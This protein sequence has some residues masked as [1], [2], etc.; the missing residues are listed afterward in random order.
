MIRYD[1]ATKLL[2]VGARVY[3]VKHW[4]SSD[5]YGARVRQAI[6]DFENRWG[7]SVI[8]GSMNY[9]DNYEH[10]DPV[11]GI[12]EKE[13]Q[14]FVEEPETVEV[15]VFGPEPR[16]LPGMSAETVEWMRQNQPISDST[17]ES[18]MADR[19]TDL[20]CDPFGWLDAE[21]VNLLA[22]EVM[23]LPSHPTAEEMKAFGEHLELLK[24]QPGR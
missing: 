4:H 6:L 10:H 20:A 18:M 2:H 12:W 21:L 14:P 24:W 17:A 3:P 1:P 5:S 7:L 19:Q 16:V 11:P 23:K 9:S 22:D 8:W 15:G 13:T